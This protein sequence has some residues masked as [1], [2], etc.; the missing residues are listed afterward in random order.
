MLENFFE[1]GI[2][3]QTPMI[4]Y[5]AFSV[6]NKPE[7]FRPQCTY[8]HHASSHFSKFLLDNVKECCFILLNLEE[9]IKLSTSS[10]L[11]RLTRNH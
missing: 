8:G 10:F 3:Q 11:H 5:M 2:W 1:A 9:N 7:T 4:K 6:L